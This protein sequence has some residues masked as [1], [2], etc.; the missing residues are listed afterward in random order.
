VKRFLNSLFKFAAYTAATLVIVLA[1]AVGLFRLFLP[2]LPEYQEQIKGWASDAIGMQVEF[3]GMNARWGLRGPELDFYDAELIRVSNQTRA[4]AARQVSVGVALSRLI[5]D[6]K[7]VIDRVTVRDTAIEVRQ[8]EDGRWWVQ[9]TAADELMTVHS[10][11]TGEMGEIE[12]VGQN[13]ELRFLQPG[14]E[15]PRFID[16]P[17]VRMIRDD[18][19]IA[20]DAIARLPDTLGRTLNMSAIQLLGNGR[21]SWD[22]SVEID[23]V[24]LAEAT[25]L[26]GD[27]ARGFSSGIGDIDVSLVVADKAISRAVANVDFSD[28]SIGAGAAFDV[29][30]GIE[31]NVREDG[32]LAAAHDF[33]LVT[34]N[35]AWPE[36]ILRLEANKNVADEIVTLEAQASYVNLSD[37][38]L[39]ESWFPAEQ[40]GQLRAY[41]ADG[42][43]RGLEAIASDLHR[44]KP[45]FDVKVQLDDIGFAAVDKW[46]GVRGF[47]GS[48]NGNSAGG[49]I[50]IQAQD[51]T[52]V[53]KELFPDPLPI[54]AME[55]RLTWRAGSAGTTIVSDRIRVRSPVASSENN[56]HISIS[57]DGSA[58]F[59][60]FVSTFTVADLGMARRYIPVNLLSPKLY[61]WF[62]KSLLSGSIPRG[63]ARLYGPIDKFPFDDGE[64]QFFLQSNVRNADFKYLPLWPAAD[65]VDVDVV[66]DNARLYTE[67]GHVV[68]VGN[69]VIDAKVEIADLR[70]PVLTIDAVA[71]GTL[72]TV[73][74]FVVQSPLHDLFGGQLDRINVEG[75]AA[76][77]LDLMIPLR[78]AK[79]FE[80][81]TRIRANAGR[82]QVEGFPAPVSELTGIV[83]ITRDSIVSESLSGVF[84][85]EPIDIEL[86][87]ANEDEPE[88][89]AVA[90]ATGMVTSAALVDELGLPL[91]QMLA[92]QSEYDLDI[93]F[94]RGGRETP[95]PLTFDISSDLVGMAIALPT[96]LGKA[97]DEVRAIAGDI[98]LSGAVGRIESAGTIGNDMRWQLALEDTDSGWDFDR[99]ILML[100]D[101]A[102]EPAETRGLH[103]RGSTDVLRFEDWL[104]LSRS[105]ETQLG[106]AERIRSIDVNVGE[107]FLL[108]QRLVDHRVRI[109]RSARDW[110]VQ[111]EGESVTGSVFVPYDFGGDRELVL[112][113]QRLHLPGDDV[114]PESD[115]PMADPRR[116]PP[117]SLR[118]AEFI[119]GE[120]NLGSVQAEL[121]RT[122][123]GL[124]TDNIFATDESFEIVGTGRWVVDE[125]DPMGQRTYITATLTSTDVQATMQRLNYDPGIAGEDMSILFDLGWS[126]GPRAD[127]LA[128][129]D[130]QVQARFGSGQLDEVE[131][132]AGRVFGLMSVVALPRRLSLDFRDVFDKGFGFDKIVGTFRIVDGQAYTC[133]LSLQGPAADIG[134]VGRAGLHDRDYEQTAVVSA[135]V[136]NTL[137][138]VGAVVAGP[139]AA[140]ALFLFSQIFKKPLQEVGQVYYSIEGD[141]DDPAIDSTNA[142][143]F[144]R[145]GDLAGCLADSE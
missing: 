27:D 88:F 38:R 69:Q 52:V 25:K 81:E 123:D 77:D 131:P 128:T 12:I 89:S 100:G 101:A 126:G 41:A 142:D 72:E 105:G 112:D 106:T 143:G 29:S 63:S 134:I 116:L 145:A 65:L 132:G 122:P 129:L 79:E 18:S 37:V 139:Q 17:R 71:T 49:H 85:G 119:L 98:R 43:L 73:R 5:A 36:S 48:F 24:N 87:V 144:A 46:P 141:W 22:V 93:R 115:S 102:L 138:L 58:P 113:M 21:R 2:R 30:G 47:S 33:V 108:G 78:D 4:V 97:E 86:R 62:Q 135:N 92:G 109:D 13:I 99:G 26:T 51:M 83:T 45:K 56:V 127:F 20:L 110:L 76:F 23:G 117:I 75:D 82:M 40:R 111:L 120:R 96:P 54:N 53:S 35:G 107:V 74:Q 80:I 50:D 19:R 121:R 14:D 9:G 11:G 59:V 55:G 137:P 34:E 8:L 42:E 140:A 103:V 67:R 61:D 130:G 10:A 1:I 124:E 3:S 133:N 118:A 66:V 7:L 57:D 90:S 136:G 15:R 60:D 94:P 6:R 114:S 32:W 44:V 28:V 84:L 104:G 31:F 64:G 95:T 70:N 39:F 125:T 68:N 91:T 16:V